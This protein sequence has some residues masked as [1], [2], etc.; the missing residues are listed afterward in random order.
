VREAVN[1][2]NLSFVVLL[3]TSADVQ[4]MARDT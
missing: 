2:Y 4:A 1:P 3:L